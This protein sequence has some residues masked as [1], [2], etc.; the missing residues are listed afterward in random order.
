MVGVKWGTASM[1][2]VAITVVLAGRWDELE[3]RLFG[4]GQSDS[5]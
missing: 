4:F 5:W 3:G 1:V 2:L